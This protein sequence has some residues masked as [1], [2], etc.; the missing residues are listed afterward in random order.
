M[1]AALGLLGLLGCA[2]VAAVPAVDFGVVDAHVH[3]ITTDNGIDYLW[4]VDHFASCKFGTQK[5]SIIYHKKD[6]DLDITCL[7]RAWDV[8]GGG[9]GTSRSNERQRGPPPS[10]KFLTS[11]A[12][13]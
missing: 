2:R 5:E 12:M 7:N 1:A 11:F 8:L 6:K 10:W 3:L 13:R 4:L 9:W